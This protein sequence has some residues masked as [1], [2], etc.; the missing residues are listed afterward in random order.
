MQVLRPH[1][2]MALS[3][4]AH[5]VLQ[6]SSVRSRVADYSDLRHRRLSSSTCRCS[7]C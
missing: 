1:A 7:W 2:M 3:A 4:T 6:T 5:S